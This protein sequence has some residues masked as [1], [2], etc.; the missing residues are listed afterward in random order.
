MIIMKY[1]RY[2]LILVC[3]IQY[4]HTTMRIYSPTFLS[5]KYESIN[6][7]Y[8]ISSFGKIPYGHTIMGN[9]KIPYP[10]TA[11]GNNVKVDYDLTKKDPLIL[12]VVRGECSFLEKVK[13]GQSLKASLVI[14]VDNIDEEMNLI[15]PWTP[16]A[17]NV[18]IRIPSV[19]LDR[20]S[21]MQLIDDLRKMSSNRDNSVISSISFRINQELKSTIHYRFDLN[22]RSLYETFFE[23][24]NFY[25]ELQ[26]H[27]NIIPGYHI[28]PAPQT[29]RP[30]N[31]YCLNGDSFCER[32]EDGKKVDIKDEPLYESLR[33]ICISRLNTDVW[34]KYVSKFYQYCQ[35][36]VDNTTELV[37]SLSDCSNR[38]LNDINDSEIKG[39]LK[40]CMGDVSNDKVKEGSK[41][42]QYLLDNFSIRMTITSPSKEA[43]MINGQVIY[44]RMTSL[45]VLKEICASLLSK[46]NEC[47]EID[48]LQV[49]KRIIDMNRFSIK[50]ALYY[51]MKLLLIGLVLTAAFYIIYKIKLRREMEKKLN[52]E[53]DSALA[54]YYMQNR[55]SKMT[56]MKTEEVPTDES[57]T[58]DTEVNIQQRTDDDVDDE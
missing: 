29:D 15:V 47:K 45:D 24:L 33:Q 7:N 32:R 42:Y 44:G 9:I 40:E 22:D 10:D 28:E 18:D 23:L 30:A 21:G 4:I 27:I 6:F 50:S 3:M 55:G 56:D 14:I 57:L 35:K 41:L 49:N 36:K 5:T 25:S 26:K 34:W 8:R 19:V 20:Q 38:I 46:P 1:M 11:C 39:Q 16:D 54:N 31:L 51:L 17:P 2:A 53:V 52:A 48:R 58:D 12:L 13:N 43:I 37:T